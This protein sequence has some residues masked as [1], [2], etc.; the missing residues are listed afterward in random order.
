MTLC[1]I[2]AGLAML[3][4]AIG[5]C[6]ALAYSVAEIGIRRPWAGA[7]CCEW[8]WRESYLDRASDRGVGAFLGASAMVS[9]LFNVKPRD[10]LVFFIMGALLA[11]CRAGR[12]T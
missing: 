9:M 12:L 1:L 2:F 7:T 3:L 6:G 5:I 4:V 10:P 8:S 11:R